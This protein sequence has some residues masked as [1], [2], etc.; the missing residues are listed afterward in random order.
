[1]IA[2]CI[3]TYNHE[4]FIAQ[5][6]E[7]VLAQECDESLRV[8]IGDDASTDGT[9]A[10]CERYEAK[11]KRIIYV[12]RE[13]NLGLVANTIDLY[14]RI[15]KD[16]CKYIAMLDGDDYWTDLH[17][18]QLQVDFLRSHPECSFVH[19]GAYEE[20]N[21]HLTL[22][23]DTDFPKGDISERYNLFGARQTNSTIVFHA[24]LLQAIPLDELLAQS[25]P[26]LDYP[27]YGLMA[28]QTEFAYLP[29]PTTVWRNHVSISQPNRLSE[30]MHYK[31]ERIRMWKWLDKLYPHRFHYS[32]RKACV[33]LSKQVIAFFMKKC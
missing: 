16:G 12:R 11:D 1:M 33:W 17:K 10:I 29:M 25:F 27:L 28:Q 26:V 21:E 32:R 2:V 5:A 23:L 6:I 20:K 9:P 3:T 31:R 14:R 30:E 22:T 19:T 18:L 7:S 15:L 8:Y 4:A 13:Q 24:D